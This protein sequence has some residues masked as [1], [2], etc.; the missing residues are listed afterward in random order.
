MTVGEL[1]A[2]T[3]SYELA[4]WQAYEREYGPLGPERGDWQAASV[5][6]VFASLMAD[7]K[8]R[9]K[10]ADFVLRWGGRRRQSGEEQMSIFRALQA[11]MDAVQR[12][13]SHGHDR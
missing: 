9:L 3:S 1:L 6:H 8:S 5:A 2:R 7:K 13:G 12:N 4:E 11:Q 10:L